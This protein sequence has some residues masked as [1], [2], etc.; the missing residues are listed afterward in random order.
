[1]TN[2]KHT[3]T[4]AAHEL[5]LEEQLRRE[6]ARRIELERE[7][8]QCRKE[9]ITT[10]AV[11]Y[12]AGHVPNLPTYDEMVFAGLVRG[13]ALTLTPMQVFQVWDSVRTRNVEGDKL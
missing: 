4:F 11:C 13:R 6:R 3:D 9:M 5:S 2:E 12:L 7:L 8:E 10:Q 1:M